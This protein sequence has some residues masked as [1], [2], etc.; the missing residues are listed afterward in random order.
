M[1]D[2]PAPLLVIVGQTSSGKSSLSLALA[3]QFNG[4]I[5]CADSWTVYKGFDIGTAK[6]TTQDQ[7]LVLHHLIDIIQ[8]GDDFTAV[9]FKQRCV[10]LLDDISDRNKLPILTGGNG[11][12]I[13]SVIYDY[14]FMP[15]GEPGQ[16]ELLRTKSIDQ[17]LAI[18]N[19]KQI[20]LTGIDIRNSRRVIRAIEADGQRPTRQPMRGNTL[21]IGISRNRQQLRQRMEQRIEGMFA[22]GL[23]HEVAALVDEYGWNTEAMKAIG[24]REF[25]S[26]FDNDISK[27]ELKR[28]ILRSTLRDL[29]KRQRTWFK[30]HPQIV[31]VSSA[32]EATSEVDK[33]LK[34]SE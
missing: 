10:E 19:T 2:K 17:L 33:F 6:P 5:I 12:Y 28:R 8:P 22:D 27:N 13:D 29:A 32:E 24:Y 4:E 15:P 16:R 9:D 34:N 23:T 20:D 21:M 7:Q 18:A 30:K 26:Y 25:K 3:Q 11:L 14:S 1:N 31:W